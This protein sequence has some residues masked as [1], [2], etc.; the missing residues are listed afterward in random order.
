MLQDT[1]A[2]ALPGVATTEFGALGTTGAGGFGGLGGAGAAATTMVMFEVVVVPAPLVARIANVYVPSVVG[3]PER[4][5]VLSSKVKPGGKAPLATPKPIVPLDGELVAAKV[6]EV[7]AVP[8]TP[9][10]SGESAVK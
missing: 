8:A 1:V 5:P 4:T 6:Y 10:S 2:C 7:Y 3:V 9:E